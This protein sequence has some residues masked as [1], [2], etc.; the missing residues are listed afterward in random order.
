VVG[1]NN[2]VEIRLEGSTAA[3]RKVHQ[4][5]Y[6]TNPRSSIVETTTYI[7]RLDVNAPNDS[8]YHDIRAHVEPT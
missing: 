4:K 1:L 5:V 6:W 2:V 8:T 7:V 3:T